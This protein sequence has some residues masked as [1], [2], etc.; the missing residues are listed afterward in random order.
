MVPLYYMNRYLW[1]LK[2]W[3]VLELVGREPFTRCPIY[4]LKT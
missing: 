4:R 1:N 2:D 3:G